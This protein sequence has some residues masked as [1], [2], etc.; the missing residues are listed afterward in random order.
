MVVQWH[1]TGTNVSCS[2]VIGPLA[3]FQTLEFWQ[4]V[5]HRF[6]PTLQTKVS[7]SQ[8]KWLFNHTFCHFAKQSQSWIINYLFKSCTLMFLTFWVAMPFSDFPHAFKLIHPSAK[9]RS[10]TCVKTWASYV[11]FCSDVTKHGWVAQ[12]NCKLLCA[13]R[14]LGSG[15][16]AQIRAR[17]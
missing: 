12:I 5:I 13:L 9:T 14:Q 17:C 16:G 6:T 10:Q 2:Y 4:V 7:M 15:G 1:N 8:T 11:I 3:S